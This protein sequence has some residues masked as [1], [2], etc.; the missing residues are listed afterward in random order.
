M[1]APAVPERGPYTRRDLD[2]LPEDG[3]GYELAGGWLTELPSSP[4]HDHGARRIREILSAA[5]ASA[6]VGVHVAG[7][8]TDVST[9]AG[10][11]RPDALVVSEDTA[12]SAIRGRAIAY[13]TQDLLLVAEVVSPR[14]ASERADRVEKVRESDSVVI[15][16]AAR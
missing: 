6:G 11:R 15:G 8:A 2:A 1:S 3:K 13:R 12:R 10:I 14:S 7:G 4:W 9:P 5:A 16:R